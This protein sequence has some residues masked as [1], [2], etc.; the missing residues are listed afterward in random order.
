MVRTITFDLWDTL[1]IDN[2]DEERRAAAGLPTKV[3]ARRESF[4]KSVKR[5]RPH[6]SEDVV[7]TAFEVAQE[8]ARRSWKE[9]H[10]TLTVADRLQVAFQELGMAPPPDF[11]E[12]VTYWE[13]MEVQ[14]P[15]VLVPHI[16][17]VL[18]KVAAKYKL[19]IISD[20][21]VT[22]G[23]GLRQIL[24]QY[25][26]DQYFSFF[27]FSDEAGAAKPARRVFDLAFM[28]AECAPHELIHIGDREANDIVG[29]VQVGARSILYTGAVNR[30][31]DGTAAAAVCSD[32]R[33]LMGIL[34]EL[35]GE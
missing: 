3:E 24:R 15:P 35:D 33:D 14:L 27:V 32:Y 1:V 10:V 25:D 30:G 6:F 11:S 17:E 19:G 21:I 16:Q 31:T 29:P 23:S 12:L 8:T 28:F 34:E 18:P 2:S 26:L 9:A 4:M 7:A 13:Q 5:A 22:P 20:T